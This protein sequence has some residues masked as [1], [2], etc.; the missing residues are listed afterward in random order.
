MSGL[1]VPRTTVDL[2][3]D[4]PP[5]HLISNVCRANGSVL[6]YG[7]TGIGK[8]R[9]IWQLACAW[10]RGL[11]IFG[12]AP[13]KPLRITIVEAD[14]FRADF[15]AMIKEMAEHHGFA[16]SDNLC[17]YSRDDS[18]PFFVDGTFGASL[19][20]HNVKWGTDLTIYDAV[21]DMH[22][23][24]PNDP[25]TAVQIIR[26]LYGASNDKA[27]LGVLVKRKG[28]KF[29]SNE[30]ETVDELLGSQAWARAAST[31]WQMTNV[32]SLV[33][34]KHRLCP[35]PA[36]IIFQ[37]TPGGI[38]IAKAASAQGLI[39]NEAS[40]GY[41]SLRELIA[42]VQMLPGY[43]S[44]THPYKERM[45]RELASALEKKGHI[46]PTLPLSGQN[47]EWANRSAQAID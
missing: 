14:M 15:E 13:L 8:T 36:P 18:L 12:L 10:S 19:L 47:P 39:I 20:D 46:T 24:D 26:A 40:K 16:P 44:M 25:R 11:E 34:V 17:W 4:P 41:Q 1:Y 42:R 6:L 23:G 37:V 22:L 9:L 2:S 5:P 32:P 3:P 29:D 43:Q 33:W 31:V 21:S 27:Y 28:Y 30:E 7:R 38:F 45:L 35:K